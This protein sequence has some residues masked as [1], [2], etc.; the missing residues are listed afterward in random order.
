[1]SDTLP[2]P[3][4]LTAAPTANPASASAAM[5]WD[6]LMRASCYRDSI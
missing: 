5:P 2:A 6:V 4:A 3:S 1:M